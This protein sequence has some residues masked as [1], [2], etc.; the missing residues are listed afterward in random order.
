LEPGVV[1]GEELHDGNTGPYAKVAEFDEI[2]EF[3]DTDG[4]GAA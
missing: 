1:D 4:L 2:K 3:T